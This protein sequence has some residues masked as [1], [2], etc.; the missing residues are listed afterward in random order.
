MG[1]P[2]SGLLADIY[3]NYFE[4][5]CIFHNKNPHKK[6]IIS[7]SRYIDDTFL[8]FNG[9]ERQINNL[10][11]YINSIDK[12]IKFTVEHQNNNKIN[13]LDLSIKNH[14]NSI[15][16]SIYRKPT[17]TDVTIH[18]K[19]YHPY[20]HKLAA[21]NSFVVRLLN[22]PLDKEDYNKEINILKHIAKANGYKSSIIDR[23]IYK[24]KNKISKHN[25]NDKT[26]VAA[27]YTNILPDIIKNKLK[28]LNINVMFRTTNNIYNYF[29]NKTKINLENKTGIY[30]LKCN[31]CDKIYLG[32]TGRPFKERFKEHLP[33]KN[34]ENIK[35]NFAKH[36]VNENH[37]YTN[38]EKNL[39]PVHL[40]EKGRL[41]TAIEEYEIYKHFKINPN[42]LLNDQLQ[43]NSNYLYDTAIEKTI[44][45]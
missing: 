13:F 36:I 12:Q 25:Y 29:K 37:N 6:Q 41:M 34:L 19:S 5:E 43:F 38:L 1:S 9:T 35:S 17:A 39:E 2:L 31:D 24:H 10:L 14:N 23:L 8:I 21:Y 44:Y 42:I 32:Q 40:C 18:S 7:Y 26:F 27:N 15:K 45:K 30:K 33:T 11:K 16:F 4:N 3:L 22:T 20:T 28:K